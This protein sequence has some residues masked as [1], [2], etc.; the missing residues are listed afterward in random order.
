MVL[1]IVFVVDDAI[2]VI[3]NVEYHMKHDELNPVEATKRAMDEVQKPVVAIAFVLSAVFIPVAFLGGITS[4]FYKQFALTLMPVL[5]ALLMKQHNPDAKKNFLDKLF[6][7]FNN[8]FDRTQKKNT[9][10]R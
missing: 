2:V 5:C 1:A 8:W 7:R 9:R 6:D 10:A 3:G 4:V